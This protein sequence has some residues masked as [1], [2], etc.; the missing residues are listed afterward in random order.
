MAKQFS[1]LR[2]R[3]L[4]LGRHVYAVCGEG[5]LSVLSED[6]QLPQVL[7]KSPSFPHYEGSVTCSKASKPP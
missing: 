6:H 3:V 7:H 1:S 5:G 2:I 4:A